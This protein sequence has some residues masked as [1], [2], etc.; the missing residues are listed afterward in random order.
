MSSASASASAPASASGGAGG[1]S[2]PVPVSPVSSPASAATSMEAP[3]SPTSLSA[4]HLLEVITLDADG[5]LVS[6]VFNNTQMDDAMAFMA[7]LFIAF[8]IQII[9]DLHGVLDLTDEETP[10]IPGSKTLYCGLSYVG[11]EL[12]YGKE[13]AKNSM[14]VTAREALGARIKSG[15]LSFAILVFK[16]GSGEEE[17]TFVKPG[18]K[19]WVIDHAQKSVDKCILF[20]DDSEDHVRSAATLPK[21]FFTKTCEKDLPKMKSAM[22]HAAHITFNNKGKSNGAKKLRDLVDAWAT[23]FIVA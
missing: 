5:T 3:T 20:V 17:N 22:I 14:R 9:L 2:A 13:G 1:P 11:H 4:D 10:F 16:R 15:Q 12:V 18:S 21:A 8:S 6:T 23:A 19:A 7:K